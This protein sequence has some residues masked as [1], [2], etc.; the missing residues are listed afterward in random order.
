MTFILEKVKLIN[1]ANPA[2]IDLGGREACKLG[3]IIFKC[4]SSACWK[5]PYRYQYYKSLGVPTILESDLEH[6][7][8]AFQ[9]DNSNY[10]WR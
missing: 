7:K 9:K 4:S 6:S 10:E 8:V 3:E 1:F 2:T 5:C